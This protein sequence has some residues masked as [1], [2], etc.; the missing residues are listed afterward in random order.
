MENCRVAGPIFMVLGLIF[1]VFGR[2]KYNSGRGNAPP[3]ATVVMAAPTTAAPVHYQPQVG[4]YPPQGGAYPPQSHGYP[5]Q[6]HGYQQTGYVHQAG[7]Y[8][9]Q[10]NGYQQGGYVHQPVSYPPQ[11]YPPQGTAEGQPNGPPA[12]DDGNSAP[13]PAYS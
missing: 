9:P 5:V 2:V 6:A 7:G 8:P 11:N 13:P 10:A 12:Y 3:P 4:G 1:C